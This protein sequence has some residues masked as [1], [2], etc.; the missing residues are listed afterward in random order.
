MVAVGNMVDMLYKS[1]GSLLWIAKYGVV[2]PTLTSLSVLCNNE[3]LYQE[4]NLK[5]LKWSTSVVILYLQ[6]F[7]TRCWFVVLKITLV[8]QDCT[9]CPPPTWVVATEYVFSSPLEMTS[10]L[11]SLLPTKM[12]PLFPELRS[13]FLSTLYHH[14][15]LNNLKLRCCFIFQIEGENKAKVYF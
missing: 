9:P 11:F 14:T 6:I 12:D 5:T 7:W 8:R 1:T 3:N 15:W 13:Y 10:H 4:S 2:R